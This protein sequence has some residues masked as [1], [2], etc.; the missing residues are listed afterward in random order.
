VINSRQ[1]F[2]SCWNFSEVGI[3][4][5]RRKNFITTRFKAA[6]HPEPD[7]LPEPAA[8]EFSL[9]QVPVFNDLPVAQHRL[10]RRPGGGPLSGAFGHILLR[11]LHLRILR[12]ECRSG[13]VKGGLSRESMP[14]RKEIC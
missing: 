6:V 1:S 9:D 8:T 5:T 3:R 11:S 2:N 4:P 12:L 14:K 7:K 13:S 10:L